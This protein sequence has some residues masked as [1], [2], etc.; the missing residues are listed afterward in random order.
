LLVVAG[1]AALG[2]AQAPGSEAGPS[3]GTEAPAIGDAGT[4]PAAATDTPSATDLSGVYYKLLVAEVAGHRGRLDLA[5]SH[6]LDAAR[7]TRDPRIVER[8]VRI[9]AFARDEA[10]SLEAAQLWVAVAPGSHEAHRILAGLYLRAGQVEEAVAELRTVLDTLKT[11]PAQSYALLVELLARERDDQVA[12][13]VMDRFVAGAA[14][15]NL[16]QV[17]VASLAARRGKLDRAS[18]LLQQVLAR[19]PDDQGATLLYAQVLQTQGKAEQ[20]ADQLA[21]AVARR[22]E[23]TGL[24]LAY[25][26]LLVGAKRYDQ[27]A[28][29]FRRVVERSPDNA[30]ARYSLALLLMQAERLDEAEQQLRVLA[31]RGTRQQSARFYLGQ[32]AES[33]R[34]V[35]EAISWYRQ[36][37]QG[38]HFLDAQ[39][40][41]AALLAQQGRLDEARQ[42]LQAVETSS[43]KDQVRL[44]LVE[45]E[46]LVAAQRL[47]DAMAVHDLALSEFPDDAELLYGRAMLAERMDRIDLLERDLRA[48]LKRDPQ[49]VQALNALGYTLADR[50]DRYQEAYEL[51]SK[52]LALRPDDFYILDSMGWVLYRMQRYPEALEYLRRAAA[53]SDDPE[54]AAHLG[55]VLWVS[56][57]QPAAREVW[58]AALRRKPDAE[59]IQEVMRRFLP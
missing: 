57:D 45:A 23:D 52:A 28:G 12:F 20:A 46:I 44:F 36:V 38:E 56:G 26:R 24:R 29:E 42:H 59:P 11:T 54:V 39:V 19:T 3:A 31:S 48:I 7:L 35:D 18:E 15:E 13:A 53:L 14:D 1:C 10:A 41:A 4:Q 17:A 25:A 6:Y 47:D 22:P 40:R 2:P 49:H 32:I 21:G 55:E 34:R 8:A 43:E 50:T 16:A 5:V 37:D 58:E 27:A 30:D 33:R 51:I 9:A